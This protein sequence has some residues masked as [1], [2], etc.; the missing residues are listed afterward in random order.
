MGNITGGAAGGAV[1]ATTGNVRLASAASS[2]TSMTITNSLNYIQG[3]PTQSIQDAIIQLGIDTIVGGISGKIASDMI[4]R[5][6]GRE[7]IKLSTSLFGKIGTRTLWIQGGI[8]SSQSLVGKRIAN[9][10]VEQ[11]RDLG[12]NKI[13]V[14]DTVFEIR[15]RN[16]EFYLDSAQ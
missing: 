6:P 13:K 9:T 8:E 7:P 11:L 15:A 5:G 12:V 2:A 3:K 4:P 1:L 16:N 10:I 14:N